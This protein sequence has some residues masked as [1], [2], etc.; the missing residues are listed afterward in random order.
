MN[1]I[2]FFI[3]NEKFA[4]VLLFTS[5][6]DSASGIPAHKIILS[7]C[8]HVSKSFASLKYHDHEQQSVHCPTSYAQTSL[9]IIHQKNSYNESEIHI[10]SP[11]ANASN[12]NKIR[13]RDVR[14]TEMNFLTP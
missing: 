2:S 3:R 14:R 4:D 7:S 6:S 8:S 13:C 5:N 9:Y 1:F 10:I 11:F 12:C